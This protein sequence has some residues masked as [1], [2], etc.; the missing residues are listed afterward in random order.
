MWEVTGEGVL[1]RRGAAHEA[2]HRGDYRARSTPVDTPRAGMV[3]CVT[4]RSP[5]T[6]AKVACPPKAATQHFLLPPPAHE[7][8]SC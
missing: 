2:S 1:P 5:I 8:K 7:K 6:V 4:A 3:S